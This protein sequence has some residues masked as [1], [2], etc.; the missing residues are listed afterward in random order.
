MKKPTF[1]LTIRRETLRDLARL[2]LARI[3]GGNPNAPLFDTGSPETGCPF[4]QTALL[5]KQ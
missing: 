2:D 5:Q 4:V 3:A 1:K